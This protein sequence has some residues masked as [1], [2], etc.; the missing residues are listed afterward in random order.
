M[1]P[2]CSVVSTA[3]LQ[4]GSPPFLSFSLLSLASSAP[5]LFHLFLCFPAPFLFTHFQPR[6]F[7][8]R[9]CGDCNASGHVLLLPQFSSGCSLLL[10]WWGGSGRMEARRR[11]AGCHFLSGLCASLCVARWRRVAT[12]IRQSS[13]GTVD[14][15]QVI[16]LQS[17]TSCPLLHQTLPHETVTYL[18]CILL[19]C[20]CRCQ[21][22]P[23]SRSTSCRS[24]SSV[25]ACFW[26]HGSAQLEV[27]PDLVCSWALRLAQLGVPAAM[28]CS[29]ALGCA[30]G[31]ALLFRRC[32]L[33]RECAAGGATIFLWYALGRWEMR[34][35]RHHS[36]DKLSLV[37]SW[38]VLRSWRC[39]R[40]ELARLPAAKSVLVLLCGLGSFFLAKHGPYEIYIFSFGGGSPYATYNRP[41]EWAHFAT[42]CH[43]AFFF[44]VRQLPKH[45][46]VAPPFV[47]LLWK[48]KAHFW[49]AIR[50]TTSRQRIAFRIVSLP[51]SPVVHRCHC[52][53]P[54]LHGPVANKHGQGV[55]QKETASLWLCTYLVES[56]GLSAPWR[57]G[58]EL[59]RQDFAAHTARL[60]ACDL[61]AADVRQV[62]LATTLYSGDD[63]PMPAAASEDQPPAAQGASSFPSTCH[64]YFMCAQCG[65]ERLPIRNSR[66]L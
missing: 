9:H 2:S 16:L 1:T 39:H 44:L 24:S 30:A 27:P 38:A 50:V 64:G 41:R 52:E 56:H 55:H 25:V 5:L 35:W 13:F 43:A 26:A 34:S 11:V 36:R 63:T 18:R 65:P 8:P 15:D 45:G 61:S 60:R 14:I 42:Q 21:V 4:T 32:A 6:L 12:Q 46:R 22:S 40:P 57:G 33:G 23:T 66:Y 3:L 59:N 47:S 49:R 29:W 58:G 31:G 7:L 48:K 51:V 17:E 10:P 19:S 37:C 54:G 20:R 62:Q 53:E 28:V